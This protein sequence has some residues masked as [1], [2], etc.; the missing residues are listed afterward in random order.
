[1]DNNEYTQNIHKFDYF[2]FLSLDNLTN[3]YLFSKFLTSLT[4]I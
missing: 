3:R 1:M 2:D 4:K